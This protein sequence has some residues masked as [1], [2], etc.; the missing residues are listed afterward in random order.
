VIPRSTTNIRDLA[1]TMADRMP[2]EKSDGNERYVGSVVGPPATEQTAVKSARRI[3]SL[4]R[5]PPRG[6]CR[7][8]AP[9]LRRSPVI[10]NREMP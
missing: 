9:P 5:R 1:V 8:S 6:V 3:L 4:T 10:E 7:R 2:D